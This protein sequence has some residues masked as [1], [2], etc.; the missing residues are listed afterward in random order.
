MAAVVFTRPI[1]VQ[2]ESTLVAAAA[3]GLSPLALIT[4]GVVGALPEAVL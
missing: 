4:A 3:M 2:A 1:P